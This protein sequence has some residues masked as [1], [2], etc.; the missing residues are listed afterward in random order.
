MNG[1]VVNLRR[2]KFQDVRVREACSN[3]TLDFEWINQKIFDN[4]FSRVDSYF[5]GTTLAARGLPS[6]A[7]L[8]LLEPFREQLP[9]AVFGPMFEQPATHKPGDIRANLTKALALFAA[10]GWTNTDGVLRNAKGEPFTMEVAG[11]RNQSPFMDPIYR[12]LE[13]IGVVLTKKLSDGAASRAS[14]NKFDYDYTSLSLRESR[15]P[16]SRVVA[17]FQ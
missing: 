12:N 6:A 17:Q 3:Y 1:W 5:S 9:P 13:K 2:E 15:M 16:G 4:E 11:S 7:E 10:A 8:Q 14:M